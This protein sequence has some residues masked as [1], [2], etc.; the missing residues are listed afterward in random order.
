[1]QQRNGSWGIDTIYGCGSLGPG[2]ASE[3]EMEACFG[4]DCFCWRRKF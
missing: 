3:V 1:M 4:P 2:Q